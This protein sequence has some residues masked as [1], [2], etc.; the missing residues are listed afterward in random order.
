[1]HSLRARLMAYS[2]GMPGSKQLRGRFQQVSTLAD[3]D[4]V[5]DF[6]LALRKQE[7]SCPDSCAL[8]LLIAPEPAR[9]TV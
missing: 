5:R 2:R 9:A 7:F 6:S 1:M 8:P 3:L 4:A